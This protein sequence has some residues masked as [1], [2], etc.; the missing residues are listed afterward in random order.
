VLLFVLLLSISQF[1]FKF[2]KRLYF[3]YHIP[4]SLKIGTCHSSC[5]PN[6]TDKYYKNTEHSANTEYLKQ[7]K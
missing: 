4:P 5:K 2:V 3:I 1:R 7:E 6:R